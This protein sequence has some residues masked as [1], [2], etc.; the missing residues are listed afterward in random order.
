MPKIS[1]LVP[2]FNEENTILEIL[3]R[4][5]AQRVEGSTFEVI[6]VN[7]ASTDRTLEKLRSRPD[8]YDRLI[9]RPSN[10]GKGA[11]VKDGMAQATGDYVLFQDA[12]LEYDPADYKKMIEPVSCIGAEVVIGSRFLS[13]NPERA[14]FPLHALGNKIVTRFFNLLFRARFTDVY[15][16][17]LLYRKNLVKAEELRT[18]GWQQHAEILCLAVT[19]SQKK[20]YEV[21]ISYRRRGLEGGK[22]IRYYHAIGVLA[23]LIQ[24][25]IRVALGLISR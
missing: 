25:R 5:R 24:M 20:H 13:Q 10:G 17:Y 2:A 7:D 22:K 3:E 23:I 15:S 8:L 4:V 18:A 12:D 11:A 21:S 19:R 16:C 14:R 6:V 9:E 1:V